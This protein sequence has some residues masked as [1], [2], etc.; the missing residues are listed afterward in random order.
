[1]NIYKATCL[2]NY[3]PIIESEGREKVK[4]MQDNSIL[5]RR[6]ISNKLLCE[7]A[8]PRKTLKKVCN[9]LKIAEQ[10]IQSK[11]SKCTT[12]MQINKTYSGNKTFTT[13]NSL[14]SL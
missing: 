6:R 1:M 14:T 3:L 9:K 5:M 4:I 2:G 7:N 13:V 12:R 11:K 10:D 8:Q